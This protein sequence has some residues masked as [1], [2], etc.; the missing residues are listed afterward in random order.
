MESVFCLVSSSWATVRCAGI[1]LGRH[2]ETVG[3][4]NE[5]AGLYFLLTL[6]YD[7]ACF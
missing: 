2:I 7:M 5:S 1:F 4:R 3:A 6:R